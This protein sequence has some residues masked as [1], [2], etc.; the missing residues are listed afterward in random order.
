MRHMCVEGLSLAMESGN[1]NR[2]YAVSSAINVIKDNGGGLVSAH[3]KVTSEGKATHRV[4]PAPAGMALPVRVTR[5]PTLRS[6]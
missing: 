6:S 1:Y 2:C 3:F 4:S 5:Y